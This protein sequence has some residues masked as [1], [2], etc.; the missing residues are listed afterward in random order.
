MFRVSRSVNSR[1]TSITKFT[2]HETRN[3]R[4]ASPK[5]KPIILARKRRPAQHHFPHGHHRHRI[6][7]APPAAPGPA[8]RN[9]ARG[10]SPKTNSSANGTSAPVISR[11]D[12]KYGYAG[13]G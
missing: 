2:E 1:K 12:V 5:V 3:T 6:T 10:E 13:D 9:R 7:T 4:L 11:P 8:S